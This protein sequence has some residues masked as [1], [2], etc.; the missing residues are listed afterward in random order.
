MACAVNRE[1]ADVTCAALFRRSEDGEIASI[2][3]VFLFTEKS[4]MEVHHPMNWKVCR[5]KS[6]TSGKG[7][8]VG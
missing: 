3:I 7:L 2:S 1:T 8:V 5:T 4:K 6:V